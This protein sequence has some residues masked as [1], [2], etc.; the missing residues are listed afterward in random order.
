MKKFERQCR[1]CG[2]IIE[3]KHWAPVKGFECN[4]CRN[5]VIEVDD[6]RAMIKLK[7]MKQKLGAVAI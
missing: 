5:I 2:F 3:L 7:K 1:T 4:Y 6:N